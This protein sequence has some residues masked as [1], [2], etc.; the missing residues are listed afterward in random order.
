MKCDRSH[1]GKF[2]VTGG[3]AGVVR[4]WDY[5][6][7]QLLSSGTGHSGT[8]MSLKFSPDDRQVVSV[9]DDGN[10]FIWNIFGTN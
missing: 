2:L 6:S 7:A 3:T 4:L 9:G 8:I 10:V 5:D 1:N